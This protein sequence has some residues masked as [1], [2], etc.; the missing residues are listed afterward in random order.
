M[1][2]TFLTMRQKHIVSQIFRRKGGKCSVEISRGVAGCT[3]RR[4]S[5]CPPCM[6]AAVPLGRHDTMK[7]NTNLRSRRTFFVSGVLIGVGVLAWACL[8]FLGDG[9]P[10]SMRHPIKAG[11]SLLGSGRSTVATSHYVYEGVWQGVADFSP[12]PDTSMRLY[13]RD[14][15]DR[16]PIT[17]VGWIT[18]RTFHGWSESRDEEAVWLI[19]E[20]PQLI[21][22]RPYQA[23]AYRVWRGLNP[24]QKGSMVSRWDP[25]V[26][27]PSRPVRVTVKEAQGSR[28][29]IEIT[30]PGPG[31]QP[32]HM[33]T[34]FQVRTFSP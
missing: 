29:R 20:E 12:Y 34:F 16:T 7:K 31:G 11:R 25:L 14:Q 17:M 6:A 21:E 19:I 22:G 27:A 1:P 26:V 5:G 18:T 8:N 15:R 3:I 10:Y 24:S 23:R 2:C 33:D 4:M 30:G 13:D 28:Y 32:L 9:M